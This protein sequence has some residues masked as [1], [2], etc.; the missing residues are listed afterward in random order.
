MRNGDESQ[1]GRCFLSLTGFPFSNLG[2]LFGSPVGAQSEY[3]CLDV[4]STL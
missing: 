4:I 3:V 2:R 1:G